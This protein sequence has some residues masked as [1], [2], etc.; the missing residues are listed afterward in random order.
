[1]AALGVTYPVFTVFYFILICDVWHFEGF[2]CGGHD[3]EHLNHT[4]N[5]KNCQVKHQSFTGGWDKL[6]SDLSVVMALR[7]SLALG[8]LLPLDFR[9]EAENATVLP[10][11]KRFYQILTS[12]VSQE[13]MLPTI[14]QRKTSHCE[15][16]LVLV[17]L[18]LCLPTMRHFAMSAECIC[19]K[20]HQNTSVIFKNK[21]IF[22][23]LFL[24]VK[25]IPANEKNPQ[26][27]LTYEAFSAKAC[28]N[29]KPRPVFLKVNSAD[30]KIN[31]WLKF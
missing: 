23:I 2:A 16:W 5:I 24:H 17:V 27:W 22:L 18:H 11:F 6:S 20:T 26:K 15:K 31:K 13:E 7:A 30:F 4:R 29:F 19:W 21:S 9:S 1:M 14:P 8:S 12:V 28:R 25:K 3:G 10:W